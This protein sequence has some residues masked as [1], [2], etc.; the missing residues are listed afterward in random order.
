MGP[1]RMGYRMFPFGAI[2]AGLFG[3]G[4]LALLVLGIVWLAGGFRSKAHA[5][6]PMQAAP[7]PMLTC[8]HCGKPVQAD[9]KNCPY[10][11]KKL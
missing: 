11:G 1:G 9:W 10:C 8:K 3:L 2:F 6:A 5:A 4:L 7:A